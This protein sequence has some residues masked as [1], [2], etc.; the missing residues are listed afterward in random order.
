ML[1][2]FNWSESVQLFFPTKSV[3]C[4]F[5]KSDESDILK[6]DLLHLCVITKKYNIITNEINKCF[7]NS[8]RPLF[9]LNK[10]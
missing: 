8:K 6:Y 2:A 5:N 4:T 3:Q 1:K 9:N 10:H 7:I